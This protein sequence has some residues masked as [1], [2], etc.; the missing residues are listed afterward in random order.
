MPL[1]QHQ[2]IPEWVD[3]LILYEISPRNF[4]SPEH[5]ERGGFASVA[6]RLPYLSDLGVNAIWLAGH[7]LADPT[8]FYNIWTQYAVVR[9]DVLDPTLGTEDDFRALVDAAHDR[10]IRVFLDVITHGV[11]SYSPLIEEH[12]SWF[13][14]GTWGMTDYDWFGN[15]ADLDDW[16]VSTWLGYVQDF[17]IDGYR[18]DVAM[19]RPD[20]WWDI[21]RYAS[22]SG[23]EIAIFHEGGPGYAGIVDFL[24]LNLRT[25][26]N[27]EVA[28]PT[29]PLLMR[30]PHQI[31]QAARRDL[32]HGY[33]VEIALTNGQTV[34]NGPSSSTQI[35]IVDVSIEAAPPSRPTSR[36][37]Y[38]SHRVTLTITGL[39]HDARITDVTVYQ[40]A[41]R[42]EVDDPDLP[43]RSGWTGSDL[44]VDW[45]R[46]S[47]YL[48]VR[49]AER[50]PPGTILSRQLSSHDSGW[51][52]FPAGRSPYSANGSR[53]MFGYG[54]ALAP[55]IPIFMSGE[56]FAA[57]FVPHPML[58][59]DLYGKGEHGEGTW[60]YGSWIHWDQLNEPAHSAMLE[61]ATR[62]F[63]LRRQYRHLIRPLSCDGGLGAFRSF[64]QHDP[65]TMPT[66]YGYCDS[67]QLLIVAG[68]PYLRGPRAVEIRIPWGDLPI[69]KTA[70]YHM[71]DLWTGSPEQCISPT[72]GPLTLTIAADRTPRGGVGIWEI[73][74]DRST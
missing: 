40:T 15:H 65:K 37:P 43:W 34:G 52:G 60:L 35:D 20:L 51:E 30:L 74:P 2:G 50:L 49:F 47:E 1:L 68:N 59:P 8:H 13:K 6:D 56:E 18:L 31:I 4:N 54:F 3:D 17:G 44:T 14:S 72:D 67:E 71:T 38:G 10:D 58:T 66:P 32:N 39:E 25:H 36:G 46:T 16:W 61:D 28:N 7:N 53:F 73:V 48:E 70:A 69:E 22:E 24:Q 9:P 12:P 21:R 41:S 45:T 29:D 63:A 11:M 64:D 5:P 57:D 33:L 55:A 42:S 62:L 27:T 19:Y 26:G 23:R